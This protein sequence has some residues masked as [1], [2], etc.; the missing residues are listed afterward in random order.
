MFDEEDIDADEVTEIT[1]NRQSEAYLKQ[2]KAKLVL[3]TKH[4]A[5]SASRF[6]DD[7]DSA[8]P[9]H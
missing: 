6:V 1:D 4:A 8:A 3:A 9:M 7:E 2:Q 5:D